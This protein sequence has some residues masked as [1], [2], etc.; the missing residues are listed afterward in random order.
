M[1]GGR[2]DLWLIQALSTVKNLLR[3]ECGQNRE[4]SG[5]RVLWVCRWSCGGGRRG[6]V[7]TISSTRAFRV[8]AT[9]TDAIKGRVIGWTILCGFVGG[10]CN[11]Q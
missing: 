9:V 1:G 10:L 6:R 3:K 11:E 7:W 2:R 4:D 5:E 8:Q